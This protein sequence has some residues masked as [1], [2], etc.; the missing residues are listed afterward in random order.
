MLQLGV[1]LPYLGSSQLAYLAINQI[2]NYKLANPA[3]CVIFYN[4]LDEPCMPLSVSRMNRVELWNYGG[5]LVVTNLDDAETGLNLVGINSL[6]FYVWDLEWLRGKSDFIKNIAVYRN[7]KLRL[8]CRSDSHADA[9]ENYCNRRP[10]V[11]SDFNLE[12]MF[13]CQNKTASQ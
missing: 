13:P 5:N 11:I 2:H 12:E 10:E 9:I 1:L 7:P 3:D 6:T 8:V 4:Q